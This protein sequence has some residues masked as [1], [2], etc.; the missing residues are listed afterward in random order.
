MRGWLSL[1]PYWGPGLQ[2]RHVPWLGTELVTLW[3]E[4]QYHWATPARA[5]SPLHSFPHNLLPSGNHQNTL[6][7]HDYVSVLLV[8]LVC[9]FIFNCWQIC[10]Y[11]HFFVHSLDLFFSQI[12]P[13]D[14]SYNNGLV[15]MNTFILFLPVKL[16]IHP[17][18]LNDSFAG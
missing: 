1:A 12:R 6:H 4:G 14:I 17:S 15:M 7:I 11:C 16:F 13:F 18:I 2:P 9:F 3:L 5:P 8:C 10:T